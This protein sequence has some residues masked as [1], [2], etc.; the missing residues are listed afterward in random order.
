MNNPIAFVSVIKVEE[1][2]NFSLFQFSIAFFMF[3]SSDKMSMQTE[4]KLF[5]W[6]FFSIISF[7]F[8]S[9]CCNCSSDDDSNYILIDKTEKRRKKTV[10]HNFMTQ[11]WNCVDNISNRC[12]RAT[13]W[14]A[15]NLKNC[16][17]SFPAT[18]Y[19]PRRFFF[20]FARHII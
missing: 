17:F 9:L 10:K 6:I 1:K 18:I 3:A 5:E 7:S 20:F 12:L 11:C 2:K 8:S 15:N 4:Q 19:L 13:W 14:H 16:T